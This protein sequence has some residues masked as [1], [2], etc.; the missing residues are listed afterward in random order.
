MTSA[1][2]Y[3]EQLQSM[4]GNPEA[5]STF[6]V[7]VVDA[8]QA[9]P[10]YHTA[11]IIYGELDRGQKEELWS[12]GQQRAALLNFV[13][14]GGIYRSSISKWL[15]PQMYK[16]LQAFREAWFSFNAEVFRARSQQP[17]NGLLERIWPLVSRGE[18]STDQRTT[19]TARRDPPPRKQT[20]FLF[21]AERHLLTHVLA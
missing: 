8:L 7:R 13:L 1:E 4:N 11:E 10:F 3:V 14:Q 19:E 5:A 6:Q 12:L 18:L 15:D 2:E 20:F 17:C 16:K 9:F 21:A